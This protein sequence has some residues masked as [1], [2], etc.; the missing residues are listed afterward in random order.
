MRG[1]EVG[2]REVERWKREGDSRIKCEGE[3]NRVWM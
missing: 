2:G 1:R 3:G